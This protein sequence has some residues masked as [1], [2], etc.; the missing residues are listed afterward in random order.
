MEKNTMIAC[1]AGTKQKIRLLAAG[2]NITMVEMLDRL[3][4]IHNANRP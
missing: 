2:F 4:E 3:V 1:R